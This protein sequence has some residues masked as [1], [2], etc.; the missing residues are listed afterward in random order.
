MKKI[1]L[2]SFTHFDDALYW[3]ENEIFSLKDLGYTDIKGEITLVNGE[4]RAGVITDTAQAEFNFDE[5]T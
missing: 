1:N 4:W 3:L 5:Q 2:E